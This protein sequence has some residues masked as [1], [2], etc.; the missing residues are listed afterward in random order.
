MCEKRAHSDRPKSGRPL[1]KALGQ[2]KNHSI[3]RTLKLTFINLLLLIISGCSYLEPLG[4][5]SPVRSE[6]HV[7]KNDS[8]IIYKQGMEK[9]AEQVSKY[10]NIEI[11][12]IENIHGEPFTKKVT[13]H[14]CNT[15]KCFTKYAKANK[16]INAA[17]NINGLFLPPIA[18]EGKFHQKLL[19]HELS[20]LHLFQQISLFRA[21]YIPQWFHDGLATFASSGGGVN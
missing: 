18:F 9:Q 1:I 13:I 3:M 8:R 12:N 2:Q 6:F 19:S 10:L 7:Y 16:K 11:Q 21:Y 4:N 20:H 17:V 14:I 15:T 5:V